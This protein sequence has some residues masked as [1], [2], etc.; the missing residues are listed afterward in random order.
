MHINELFLKLNYM[1]M[2]MT[3]GGIY[4]TTLF[5]YTLYLKGNSIA[6]ADQLRF[7]LLFPHSKVQSSQR[8]IFDLEVDVVLSLAVAARLRLTLQ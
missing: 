5:V 7:P 4:T 2:V 1:I 3:R 8:T 6:V